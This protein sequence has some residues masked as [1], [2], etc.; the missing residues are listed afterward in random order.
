MIAALHRLGAR[1]GRRRWAAPALAVVA[2]S[3][4]GVLAWQALTGAGGVAPSRV[5]DG[6][7]AGVRPS[8][9]SAGAAA[10]QHYEYVFPDEHMYVYDIDHGHRLVAQRTFPGLKGIR[11]VAADP[12]THALYISHGG[13]GGG[14]GDGSLLKYDLVAERVVWDR[15][16]PSGIDSMAVSR[17]GSR[18]FM[19]TGELSSSG[20]WS[21]IDAG[22][23]D[24]VGQIRAGA[25]PHNTIVSP[26]GAH[27]YLGGRDHDYL[28]VADTRNDRVVK[29][30]GPLRS[31]VRP[32][33]INGRETL[34]YTTATGFLGFQVS[35]I[36]SGRV[37]YTVTFGKRFSWDPRSFGSSA[38]SHGISLSPDERRLWVM[39]AP[40]SYVHVYDVSRVP[41]RPP[42]KIADV[43][44]SHPM[45]GDESP[46]SYD[47]GRDGWIQHSRS[48][49]YVYVGDSGD[50]ISTSTF[51]RVAYLEPL[52]NSRKHLEIDWSNGVPVATTT[53]SG[54]G[55]V[56]GRAKRHG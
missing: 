50:V 32:F 11:G 18:I 17:D 16:Y 27:V 15:S 28:E 34:A 29:R 38:P 47:C 49:R 9:A 26:G 7:L 30:I 40:N 45:S 48:G 43:K 46:C 51:R 13:D 52:H 22:S 42:R 55:Y 24:V 4:A 8:V 36:V 6:T 56:T 37:L 21:V 10:V 31:G 23:G 1:H 41:R 2:A 14:N 54:L 25:G 19:P 39:D 3:L 33:T 44:L 53:R 35:S 5:R 12:G 20:L